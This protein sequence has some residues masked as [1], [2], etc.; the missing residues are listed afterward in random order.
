MYG[1]WALYTRLG[2][3]RCAWGAARLHYNAVNYAVNANRLKYAS[4]AAILLPPV[5]IK[6]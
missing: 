5:L 2:A 3:P 6:Q 4:V 1:F